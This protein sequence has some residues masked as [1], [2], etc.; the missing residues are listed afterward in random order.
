MFIKEEE[1]ENYARNVLLFLSPQFLFN[2][3][4]NTSCLKQHQKQIALRTISNYIRNIG[5][6]WW[7]NNSATVRTKW[8]RKRR[9]GNKFRLIF[10]LYTYGRVFTLKEKQWVEESFLFATM[11][12]LSPKLIYEY[13]TQ[14]NL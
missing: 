2:Y 1:K 7:N 9:N 3:A 11:Y 12:M 8:T 14:D 5:R 6:N 10:Y 4:G 13:R